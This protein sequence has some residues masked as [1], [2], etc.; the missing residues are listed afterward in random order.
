MSDKPIIF[1]PSMVRALMEGRKTQTRRVI[2][3][4]RGGDIREGDVLISWPADSFVRQSA[5]FRPRIRVGDRLW[6][7]EAWRTCE[8]LDKI[9]PAALPL[10][11]PLYY[12]ADG[13]G[14]RV[15]STGRLRPAI[16]MPRW[17]NRITLIVTDVR[18]QR[19]QEISEA[20][21]IAEGA[22]RPWTG[23]PGTA[24]DDTRTGRSE[25]EALWNSLNA[26]RGYGWH[27]NPW[28]MAL[29]FAV[30]HG[31]IDRLDVRSAA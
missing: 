19:L 31:N 1:S 13:G 25:F 21:A 15:A 12:E 26:G 17:A 8:H 24:S 23:S 14:E 10:D 4:E 11:N 16:H 5:R 6:V 7:R 20:D 29:T 9:N 2:Q 27:T 30:N 22:L 28:V 18:V 3:P